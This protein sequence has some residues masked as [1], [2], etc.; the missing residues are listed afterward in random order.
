MTDQITCLRSALTYFE[1]SPKAGSLSG[2][3]TNLHPI[4]G[5]ITTFAA[6]LTHLQRLQNTWV[7][8]SLLDT[9]LSK[10]MFKSW[11]RILNGPSFNAF[12]T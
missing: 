7:S 3:H 6:K 10:I 8:E 4:Q 12:L 2:G 9:D 5:Y 1:G 11:K